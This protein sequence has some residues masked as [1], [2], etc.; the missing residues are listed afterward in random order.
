[1]G[2]NELAD[3]VE[4]TVTIKERW[5]LALKKW[6]PLSPWWSHFVDLT[7]LGHVNPKNMSC[8]N[9]TIYLHRYSVSGSGRANSL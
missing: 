8:Q 4:S 7:L 6:L 9:L 3:A 1:M 5:T 2:V